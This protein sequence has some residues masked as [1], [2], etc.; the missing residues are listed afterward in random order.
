MKAA[1]AKGSPFAEDS[2][3]ACLLDAYHQG[4]SVNQALRTCQFTLLKDADIGFGGDPW[5]AAGMSK[6]K[7]NVYDPGKVKAQCNAGDP[8][9]GS[10]RDAGTK[11]PL[12]HFMYLDLEKGRGFE[13]TAGGKGESGGMGEDQYGQ[14]GV[15]TFQGLSADESF[16]QQQKAVAEMDAAQKE[17]DDLVAKQT[18]QLQSQGKKAEDWEK[19][20]QM[21]AERDAAAKKLDTAKK[22]AEADPN[23]K[24]SGVNRPS[25]N[26]PSPCQQALQE[27]RE[28]LRECNRTGW[29]ALEC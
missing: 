20:A 16:K 13:Y 26:E 2:M 5:A 12:Q 6:P 18:K 3:Y 24:V 23:A 17:F 4:L 21:K 29:K 8:G 9:R 15:V 1:F 27:A 25:T 22:K 19:N 10:G 14:T 28:F 7:P 11:A